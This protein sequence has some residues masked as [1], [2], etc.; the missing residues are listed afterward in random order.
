M[1]IEGPFET[2]VFVADYTNYINNGGESS[3]PSSGV[4]IST[5]EPPIVKSLLVTDK[6]R[7]KFEAVNFERNGSLL[8]NPDGS[9]HSQCECMFYAQREEGKSWI[10]FVEMKYCE[11]KN[12]YSDTVEA[13]SQLK[14]TCR[15]LLE[16]KNIFEGKDLARYFVVSTPN[17]EPLDPFDANY[18]NQ[19][20]ML[21]LKENYNASLFLSNQVDIHTT[22][23]LKLPR[24]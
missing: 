1:T 12:L 19:D 23:H 22:V 21:T 4:Y 11:Q 3:T 7:I 14:E 13:I 24:R 6:N 20:D 8:K 17:V 10:L 5:T 18:F 15:Y 9:K 2:D 16:E